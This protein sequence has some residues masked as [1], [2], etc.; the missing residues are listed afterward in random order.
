MAPAVIRSTPTTHAIATP[1]ASPVALP[2]PPPP[3]LLSATGAVPVFLSS[4]ALLGGKTA[5]TPEGAGEVPLPPSPV[6]PWP[7]GDVP[8][9]VLL[10]PGP[11]CCS[12]GGSAGAGEALGAEG[13]EGDVYL[14]ASLRYTGPS[15]GW[16]HMSENTYW[17]RITKGSDTTGAN[18]AGL[19]GGHTNRP[20][21][22]ASAAADDDELPSVSS[23]VSV[24]LLVELL[25]GDACR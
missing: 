6:L 5:P 20:S 16:K 11:C 12:G 18:P 9:P 8:P 25:G 17:M 2:P 14:R 21:A 19:P 4:P 10:L 3:L 1:A 23:V 24:T 15:T 7:G 13:G 22:A